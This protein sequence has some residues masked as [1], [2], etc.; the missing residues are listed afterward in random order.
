MRVSFFFSLFFLSSFLFSQQAD[1]LESKGAIIIASLEGQVTVVNNTTQESLPASQVKAGGVLFDGHTVKTGPASKIILLLS[2]GTVSTIKSDSALN[3]K[4]FTQEKFDPKGKKLSE[5]KGEPSSSQT[6]MDLELGDM[7]FDV[8]KLDKRSSFNIE[9][10]VGTA[11]IRGTSGQMG[12]SSAAGATNLNINMFKGSV[13]TQLRG[14]DISTLVRQGQSFSAGISASGII[15]PPTLGKVPTSILASIEADLEASEGATGVTSVGDSTVPASEGGENIE[16]EAPSEEELQEQD[17]DQAAAAKGLGDDNGSKEAVALDKAG[18]LD[19]NDPDQVAK[20]DDFVEVAVKSADSFG[21]KK[22]KESEI[23]QK[24]ADILAKEEEIK[25]LEAQLQSPAQ[26]ERRA[27]DPDTDLQTQINELKTEVSELNDDV[28]EEKKALGKD[29][30]GF[31]KVLSEN[32]ESTVDVIIEAETLGIKSDDLI[33]KT[34]ENAENAPITNANLAKVKEAGVD[35]ADALGG[36]I[37][38]PENADNVAQLFDDL[39]NA[40]QSAEDVGATSSEKFEAFALLAS[41]ADQMTD[42]E[43][44]FDSILDSAVAMAAEEKEIKQALKDVAL[45]GISSAL[46]NDVESIIR[47]TKSKIINISKEL[48][49]KEKLKL[50]RTYQSEAKTNLENLSVAQSSILSPDDLTKLGD[51][52]ENQ[53]KVISQEVNKISISTTITLVDTNKK[54]TAILKAAEEDAREAINQDKLTLIENFFA[55]LNPTDKQ[56][57]WLKAKKNFL[58]ENSIT[59]STPEYDFIDTKF[60]AFKLEN[61]DVR[62]LA[63]GAAGF[64][65]SIEAG[66][67]PTTLIENAEALSQT[68]ENLDGPIDEDTALSLGNNAENLTRAV[69]AGFSSDSI[70]DIIAKDPEEAAAV[71]NVFDTLVEAAGGNA[72]S[73]MA[74]VESDAAD[75]A[76]QYEQALEDDPTLASS[77]NSAVKDNSDRSNPI[78]ITATI[79]AKAKESASNKL[80]SKYKDSDYYSIIEDNID[81]AKDISFALSIIGKDNAVTDEEK[82]IANA[83]EKALFANIDKLDSIMFLG[84]RFKDDASNLTIVF[85]NLDYA[86]ALNNLIR[87]FKNYPDRISLILQYPEL[88][89]ALLSAYTDFKASGSTALITDLF[90]SPDSMIS[91]LS[92]DGIN[93]LRQ[94]YPAYES[95]ILAYEDR[96]GEIKSLL[97]QMNGDEAREKFVLE[98][99]ANFDAVRGLAIR[100][101]SDAAKLDEIFNFSGNLNSLKRVSDLIKSNNVIGGQDILFNNL[102]LLSRFETALDS[103]AVDDIKGMSAVVSNIEALVADN[104][105]FDLIGDYPNFFVEISNDDLDVNLKSIPSALAY[106]LESLDLTRDE[107]K[108]VLNDLVNGPTSEGP[109]SQPPADDFLSEEY[110]AVSILESHAFNGEIPVSLVLSEDQVRQSGLFQETLEIFDAL[111]ALVYSPSSEEHSPSE[112]SGFGL[113]GGVN[114]TLTSGSYDLSNLGYNSLLIAASN[115]LTIS[116]SLA[117]PESTHLEELLFIASGNLHIAEGSTIDSAAHSLGFGSFESIEII[118]VDLHAEEEI[119]VRSLDSVVIN[120]SEFA[121]RGTGADLI[122]LAAAA[123][124]AIDNLRF[125]EQVRQITME[126]MTINLSN[127]NFP[128]GSTVNLNSAYGGID[129]VYP[130]FGSSAIGR[131]NFIENVRYNSHLLNSRSAFD[132][133]GGAISIG[134]KSN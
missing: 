112:S 18:L 6:V 36:L 86:N 80:E 29:S 107:L 124:L 132:S 24:E 82:A 103:Y 12:V 34:A 44:D 89:P 66:V 26:R 121:T 11:G 87:E 76:L 101:Q 16:D 78:D 130:N 93:K 90:A 32:L 21:S 42:A 61:V 64:N 2:N 58:S 59:E 20:A 23:K 118:N 40:E 65:E 60:K 115:N 63:S 94:D 129:G 126:A 73:A 133:H 56:S 120:N 122:H 48:T 117:L 27:N 35:N 17:A 116:G 95:E 85:N 84:R 10:P 88:S 62:S 105:Y 99:L 96:A 15:L 83:Q 111:D 13:A 110:A 45:S 43:A 91:T 41:S 113:L 98:N 81:R 109:G 75:D 55:S 134:I 72:K 14:S 123:D 128:A 38:S 28:A 30:S 70:N 127:L 71:L 125:S 25:E 8:K 69:D 92:N 106:E 49:A 51:L 7:V 67:D 108:S 79:E 39:S 102:S 131:V 1:T 22:E 57:V 50:A 4:K 33:E 119:G 37:E 47:E 54:E 77:I 3:I 53:Q 9:S 74:F 52:I 100:F 68:F 97:E 5:M 31:V 114:I 19:L 104:G 46:I